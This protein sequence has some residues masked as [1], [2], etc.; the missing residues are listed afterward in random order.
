MK[1]YVIA[2]EASGDLHGAN[3]LREIARNDSSAQFRI[4]GGERMSEAVQTPLV[5]HY[6][7]YDHMGI[8]E[9]VKHLRTILKNIEFCKQD[10]AQYKPDAILFIDFPG[11][12]LRIAPY[13]KS[14]GIKTFYYISPTVWAW[15]E[16]RVK[17]IQASV[18]HMFVELPFVKTFYESRHNYYVDFVGHPLLDSIHAFTPQYSYEE[19]IQTYSLPQKP[20]IAVMPGSREYEIRENLQT[21][22]AISH[23]FSEYEF[24]IAGMS[25]FSLEFYKK[26]ITAPN[27]S[28]VFD[29][30][31][32]LLSKARAAIVVSGTAT[33]ETALFG[34][35]EVI[36]YKTSPVTFYIAKMF[37]NLNFLGLPNLI[38]N[39]QIVPELLQTDMN[40]KNLN[41]ALHDI[42]HNN[43]TRQQITQKYTELRE[44]LGNVGAAKRTADLIQTYLH[45]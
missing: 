23:N 38:M 15:K 18:D 36:V 33:L 40:S 28:V 20:I 25:R 11:F 44:K 5:K 29:A 3:V 7:T 13:A 2:G 8:V 39:E 4:W 34:V 10:I 19:F 9:V 31:Y 35:P 41:A 42:L 26:Y 6:K 17:T 30:T 37:V 22:Q 12:N 1:Y 27:V 16:S 24:V 32:E 14:L 21:M 43:N 45:A